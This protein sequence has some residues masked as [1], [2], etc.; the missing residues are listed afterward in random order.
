MKRGIRSVKILYLS[1]I[2]FEAKRLKE[3]EFVKSMSIFDHVHKEI[4]RIR[5]GIYKIW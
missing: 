4:Y 5:E 2:S 1:V 3:K